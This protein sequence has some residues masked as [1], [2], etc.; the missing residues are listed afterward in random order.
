M[1]DGQCALWI[2][3]EI[4]LARVPVNFLERAEDRHRGSGPSDIRELVSGHVCTDR[5]SKDD[6][7]T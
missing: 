3:L 7:G 6:Q 2:E 1:G 5:G 4:A